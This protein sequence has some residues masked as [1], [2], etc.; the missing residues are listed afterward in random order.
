VVRERG[1]TAL[2]VSHDL[3]VVAQMADRII[4]LRDGEIREVGETK[5]LV[6]APSDD[7][8]K[9]LLAAAEPVERVGCSDT[10]QAA[11]VLEVH[12]LT[13]GYGPT[14]KDGVP[15]VPVLHDITFSIRPGSTLGVIGES[16]CG[17]S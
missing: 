10:R 13:A 14:G 1:A 16:G 8:T 5:R 17:K 11:P 6:T 12:N 2:Y 15:L 4:V 3:A 9:S 7:Y